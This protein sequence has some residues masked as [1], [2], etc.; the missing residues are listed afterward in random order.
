[1]IPPHYETDRE[2]LEAAFG[3]VGLVDAPNAKLL[4]I[5]NTLDLAEVE[6]SET[7]LAVAAEI[8]YGRIPELERRIEDATSHLDELQA[9]L[10]HPDRSHLVRAA[11]TF[12]FRHVGGG[13][14]IVPALVA[15][16]RSARQYP[17]FIGRLARTVV[18]SRIAIPRSS[19]T[20]LA[21]SSQR[22]VSTRFS[23]FRSKPSTVTWISTRCAHQP[24]T[25][26]P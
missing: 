12:D 11:V 6:C 8:R 1:M 3:T 4:W 14:Q 5:H 18:A 20:T 15:V 10:E 2:V 24:W 17:D 21:T 25:S 19:R 22:P 26:P 9:C 16:L 7:Y 23:T 13:L